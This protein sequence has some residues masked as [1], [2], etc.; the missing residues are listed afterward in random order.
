MSSLAIQAWP[1]AHALLEIGMRR[2]EPETVDKKV[3]TNKEPRKL[4]DPGLLLFGYYNLQ[5]PCC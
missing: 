5:R 2:G 4:K 3:A 1:H